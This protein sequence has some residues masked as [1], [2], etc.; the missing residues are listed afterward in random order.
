MSTPSNDSFLGAACWDNAV[1][2]IQYCQRQVIQNQQSLS[3]VCLFL[4][5]EHETQKIW[6]IIKHGVLKNEKL[7]IWRDIVSNSNSSNISDWLKKGRIEIV[8]RATERESKTI[9]FY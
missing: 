4:F 5:R 9:I 3:E 1:Y 2:N 7:F 6:N 8:E